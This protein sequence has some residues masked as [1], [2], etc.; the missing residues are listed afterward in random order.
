MPGE[1]WIFGEIILRKSSG[2]LARAAQG[3]GKSASLDGTSYC[4]EVALR[5]VVRGVGCVG[6]GDLRVF[7]NLSD[8]LVLN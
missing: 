3:V 5:D 2:T 4:G 7:S 1:D 6:P 8:S